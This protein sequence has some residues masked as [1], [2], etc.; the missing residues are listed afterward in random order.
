M[1]RKFV[2]GVLAFAMVFGATAPVV[3]A[4][5]VATEIVDQDA[6][7]VP[8][9]ANVTVAAGKDTTVDVKEIPEG[10]AATFAYSGAGVS[11]TYDG[12]TRKITVKTTASF[13]DDV[14]VTATFTKGSDFIAPATFTVKLEKNAD[15]KDHK[16]NIDAA[17]AT[18]NAT[19]GVKST[20][21][22]YTAAKNA[23]GKDVKIKATDLTV[24]VSTGADEYFSYTTEDVKDEKTGNVTTKITITPKKVT[25][26]ATAKMQVSA[27]AKAGTELVTKTYTVKI[28]NSKVVRVNLAATATEATI[29]D[30]VTLVPQ[31]YTDDGFGGT[32]QID[33]PELKWYLNG[34]EIDLSKPYT[35]KNVAETGSVTL[36]KNAAN[37]TVVLSSTGDI[38]GTYRVT[39]ADA[40][41]ELSASKT[42]TLKKAA[43]AVDSI[44][45]VAADGKTVTVAGSNLANV[46]PGAT[47]NVGGYN[48]Y[49][50]NGKTK[51][52]TVA[53]LNG[54][55]TYSMTY[56][57]GKDVPATVAKID[58]KTGV[59]TTFA[60]SDTD[61]L[62]SN[63]T[64]NKLVLNV[65]VKATKG[66][67][68][69]KDKTVGYTVTIVKADKA[70][71]KVIVSADGKEVANSADKASVN[72]VLTVGKPVAYT[73]K[74]VD[75][76][77]FA[78]AVG[79]GMI[80][81]VQNTNPNDTTTYATV[82]NG[83][84][85]PLVESAAKATVVGVSTANPN[86]QVEITL[87]IQGN[88][89]VP[90]ATPTAA[91]S[92]TPTATATTAPTTAPA[93]KTGK[94]TASSLRVRETPVNGTVVG[95][96]ARNTEVTITEE[97][98][99]WYKVTAGSLTG[100]VSG[101]YVEIVTPSTNETATTTANLKLRKTAKTGSVITT[102]PK[103]SKVEVLEKGSEWSKVKYNGKTGFASN[104][105]LEFEEDAV[106]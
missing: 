37:G 39:V 10:A 41:G 92:A 20:V 78:D 86:L 65:T 53:G 97:K 42:I 8:S 49:A 59:I 103:G 13:K 29:G 56:N 64:D 50:F 79:Q 45:I 72:A 19:M 57:G 33:N 89:V 34:T 83:V 73:A 7:Y 67:N 36:T 80:W 23:D 105:Y 21:E 1:A 91:P 27:R 26:T 14:K 77:G 25:G 70:A 28:E 71:D 58:A 104:A 17:D 85:T 12:V 63:A 61:A 5:P 98:D 68:G 93:T 9:I 88:G 87:Y 15:L 55:L 69:L 75:K 6:N 81:Y 35:Y 90:T 52:A 60:S 4:E 47:V 94:V 100:W 22:V 48:Y 44:A 30:N 106:G 11:A 2:S 18:V 66:D 84:V 16:L 40:T 82:S 38:A 51:V 101:E 24:R 76:N 95:K 99:G 46:Q 3:F 102:M 54:E 62:L 43:V 96:L 32:V 74:V 31:A